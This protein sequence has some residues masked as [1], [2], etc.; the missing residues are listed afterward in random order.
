MNHNLVNQYDYCVFTQDTF[1]LKNKYDFKFLSDQDITAATMYDQTPAN[2]FPNEIM[3]ILKNIHRYDYLGQYTFCCCNSFILHSSKVVQ[4]YEICA[5][6]IITDKIGSRYSEYFLARIIFELNNYKMFAIQGNAKNILDKYDCFNPNIIYQNIPD[7]FFVKYIGQIQLKNEN[8]EDICKT[9]MN[10]SYNDSHLEFLKTYQFQNKIRFGNKQHGGYVCA[11]LPPYDCYLSIGV[12]YDES[13][14]R[15][16]IEY[17]K[18][19]NEN[20]FA[21]DGTINDL[22]NN[23][24]QNLTFINKN[25]GTVNDEKTDN[26]N[27][28]F[29]RYNNIFMKMDIEGYEYEYILSL[30]SEKLQKIKQIVFEIHAINDNGFYGDNNEINLPIPF[31]QK[32]DFFKKL[33]ETHYLIHVHANNGG[34]RTLIKGN[35]IPNVIEVAYVNKNV[36]LKPP[37]LNICPFPIA[38]L[39]YQSYH[40]LNEFPTINY[41]PFCFNGSV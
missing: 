35:L 37:S 20:S 21:L 15:E 29:E 36:F 41:P 8:K 22:P 16:Y 24:S 11:N 28:F 30:S 10:Y 18:M 31:Q 33:A 2:E 34:G 25:I 12:G 39:D 13:F 23:F 14:S 27:S 5:P 4:F 40:H 19:T 6:I 32:V 1:V 9:I 26:L 3:T 7:V 17:Y 38:G